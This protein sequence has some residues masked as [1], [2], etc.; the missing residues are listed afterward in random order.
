MTSEER[1]NSCIG[2]LRAQMLMELMAL[3]AVSSI[4]GGDVF[5]EFRDASSDAVNGSLN[6][7]MCA[8]DASTGAI[9]DQYALDMQ[10]GRV[11]KSITLPFTLVS[12]SWEAKYYATEHFFSSRRSFD[13]YV[14]LI[15]LLL[16]V[17][18]ACAGNFFGISQQKKTASAV[19][20]STMSLSLLLS[21]SRVFP[22]V[23]VVC[24]CCFVFWSA[25]RSPSQR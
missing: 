4:S 23:L 14:V 6:T 2:V 22:A 21:L 10:L 17:I 1:W 15:V 25:K 8:V 12:R 9:L 5:V 3:R 19:V 24:Y 13:P 7:T 11:A 18:S 16:L 20:S